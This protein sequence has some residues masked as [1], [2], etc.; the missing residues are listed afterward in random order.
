MKKINAICMGIGLLAAT[1]ALAETPLNYEVT[2]TIN[3]AQGDA[4]IC[5]ASPDDQNFVLFQFKTGPNIMRPHS[6]VDNNWAEYHDQ[7]LPDG[8][9]LETNKDYNIRIAVTDNGTKATT[10]IAPA[11]GEEVEI[12][13]IDDSRYHFG[14]GRVGVRQS[15]DGDTDDE[16]YFD[17]FKVTTDGEVLSQ[18]DFSDAESCSF[19][20]GENIEIRDGR[21][22]VDGNHSEIFSWQALKCDEALNFTVECDFEIT[23]VAAGIIWS[24]L[25]NDNFYMW[26]FNIEREE[27]Q[28]R[29]HRWKNGG[30]SAS[31]IVLTGTYDLCAGKQI[32]LLIDVVNGGKKA[33]TYLDGVKIDERDGEFAANGKLG[34]RACRGERGERLLENSYYDNFKVTA[35]DGTVLFSETFSQAEAYFSAGEIYDERL[36]I[37]A[38]ED[39]ELRVW[40]TD[41]P[42]TLNFLTGVNDASINAASSFTVYNLQG[43]PIMRNAAADAVN[44]LPNGLYIINNRKVYINK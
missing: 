40:Q 7:A 27:P 38:P 36:H 12:C 13:T 18:E 20:L 5:F 6:R 37:V 42:V 44:A 21:L 1:P 43:M 31:D 32:H 9:T 35:N 26:Q 34:I 17:N 33:I 3:I 14:Y 2:A 4:G 19:S 28:F 41:E 24:G 29:P 39:G 22:F 16:A 8:F 11:G 25:D 23:D 15:Y 30:A 10:Y